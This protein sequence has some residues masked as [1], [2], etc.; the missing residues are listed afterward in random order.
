VPMMP[1]PT[2]PT[3]FTITSSGTVVADQQ[4]ATAGARQ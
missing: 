4:S 2:M 3:R 1:I